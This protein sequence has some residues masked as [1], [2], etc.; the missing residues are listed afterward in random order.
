MI[1]G[2][3]ATLD[4]AEMFVATAAAHNGQGQGFDFIHPPFR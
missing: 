2:T 1:H 3:N 4:T